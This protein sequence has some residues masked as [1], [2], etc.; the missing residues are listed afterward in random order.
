LVINDFRDFLDIFLDK[1]FIILN[2]C[3]F[4]HLLTPLNSPI[5]NGGWHPLI[6]SRLFFII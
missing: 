1:G 6:H 2:Y 3:L 4:I 5:E